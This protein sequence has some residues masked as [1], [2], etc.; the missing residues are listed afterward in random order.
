MD[1]TGR[2]IEVLNIVMGDTH[3]NISEYSNGIYIY[4]IKSEDGEMIKSGKFN[5]SK[6]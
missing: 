1:I 6:Y 3:L 2:I 4:Q 5:V